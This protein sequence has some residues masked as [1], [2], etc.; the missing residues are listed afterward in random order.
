MK[1]GCFLNNEEIKD[2]KDFIKQLQKDKKTELVETGG[3]GVRVER[4]KDCNVFDVYRIVGTVA[5]STK[6]SRSTIGKKRGDGDAR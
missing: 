1:I 6:R 5:I 2:V 3:L 4:F